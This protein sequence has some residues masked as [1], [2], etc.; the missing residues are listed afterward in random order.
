ME[1]PFFLS[2]YQLTKIDEYGILISMR[3]LLIISTIAFMGVCAIQYMIMPKGAGFCCV[4]PFLFGF[5][6][7]RALIS[8]ERNR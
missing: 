7:A 3:K 6:V 2:A 5:V 8:Q 1:T 4:L